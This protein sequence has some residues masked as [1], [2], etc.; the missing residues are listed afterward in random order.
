MRIEKIK[1][2]DIL[3]GY[4]PAEQYACTVK[5]MCILVLDYHIQSF[6][7]LLYYMYF[8]ILYLL[9]SNADAQLKRFKARF[10]MHFL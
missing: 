6:R 9:F 10:H 2:I 3:F 1:S 8:I 5:W 4:I 7:T